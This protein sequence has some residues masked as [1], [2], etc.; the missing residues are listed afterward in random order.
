[1]CPVR[2]TDPGRGVPLAAVLPIMLSC[3]EHG[4]RL[5]AEF[6]VTTA[7]TCGDSMPFRRATPAIVVMDRLTWE[8]LTTRRSR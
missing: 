7:V 8:G 4:C 1:M 6:A 3:P 2:V 5:E